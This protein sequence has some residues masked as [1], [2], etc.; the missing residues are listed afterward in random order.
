MSLVS[1]LGVLVGAVMGSVGCGGPGQTSND[2]GP[3]P[4]G[5]P[6][7]GEGESGDEGWQPGLCPDDPFIRLGGDELAPGLRGTGEVVVAGDRVYA[8]SDEAG[9]SVWR[10]DGDQPLLLGTQPPPD[11]HSLGCR[12]LAVDQGA[13]TVAVSSPP[14]LGQ[15]GY[16]WLYDV[17]Q[18][19]NISPVAGLSTQ[20]PVEGLAMLDHRVL[21]AA[22]HDGLS[23]LEDD[24]AGSLV[25]RGAHTDVE[26]DARKP[27]VIGDLVVVAEG[28]TGLRTYQIDKDTPTLVGAAELGGLAQDVVV[29]EDRA[30]VSTMTGA[31]IVDLSD[32]ASPEVVSSIP[33][34]GVALSLAI[35]ADGILFVADWDEIRGFDVSDEAK[36]IPALS[37][38]LPTPREHSRV[39]G[40][41]LVGDGRV[42][43]GEHSGI[44][45][46]GYQDPGCDSPEVMLDR[47]NVRFSAL[48]GAASREELVLVTNTGAGTLYVTG[49]HSSDPGV[50]ADA[51]AFFLGPGESLPLEVR[52]TTD[53]VVQGHLTLHTDDP[54]ELE[55]ELPFESA[56]FKVGLEDPVPNFHLV[57]LDG[58]AWQNA[59]LDGSVTLLA[60]FATW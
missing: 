43:L 42:V 33:T 51:D 30:F 10:L 34:P 57:D 41:A 18:P 23:V 21:V 22:K 5:P 15:P 59:D 36:P 4:G 24:G 28:T 32:P 40:L 60:Y 45:V 49:I 46:Y 9:L 26:S 11:G 31:V 25:Q 35:G 27:V 16:V 14:R 12:R 37:E 39:R 2:A 50:S 53:G 29:R 1:V 47:R 54:D 7:T 6:A 20:V 55:L 56:D 13:N 8:C 17:A 58:R 44:H 48:D 38:R 52:L 19:S 3:D